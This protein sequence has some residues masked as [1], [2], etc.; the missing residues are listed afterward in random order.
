MDARVTTLSFSWRY[1]YNRTWKFLLIFWNNRAIFTLNRFCYNFLIPFDRSFSSVTYRFLP[2]ILPW[3]KSRTKW[4]VTVI[5][6]RI[7]KLCGRSIFLWTKHTNLK[8]FNDKLSGHT[9]DTITITHVMW[10]LMQTCVPPCNLYGKHTPPRE[11][12]YTSPKNAYTTPTV[13]FSEG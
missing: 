13:R 12:V 10:H 9:N 4:T 5:W 2:V 11:N 3:Q 7:L 6:N 8:L 1:I